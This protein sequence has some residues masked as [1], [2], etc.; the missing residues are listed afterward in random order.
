MGQAC[1]R[2]EKVVHLAM[3]KKKRIILGHMAAG[4]AASAM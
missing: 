1:L 4:T 2:V 3:E